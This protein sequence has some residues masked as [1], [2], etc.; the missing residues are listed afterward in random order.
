VR[1][2]IR[3]YVE[4][5]PLPGGLRWA[6]KLWNTLNL[7]I[8]R[9]HLQHVELG[10]PRWHRL[11]Q[12]LSLSPSFGPA[13]ERRNVFYSE[14]L[15]ACGQ[16]LFVHPHTA[17]YYPGN[18]TLGD[19]VFINRGVIL[20]AP[21]PI[22]IGDKALIGPYST[23][24]SGSHRYESR[25]TPIDEQGHKYGEIRIGNDVWIGGHVCILP[26]VE[27]SDGAVIGAGAVVTKSVPAY[28][29][30]TGVPGKIKGFR[31]AP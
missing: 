23:I 24:N 1:T 25:G 6:A 15:E 27:I 5:N 8:F 16:G 12:R 28:A 22:Q 11:Q 20:M 7:A 14:T 21:V 29:I 10:S 18:I 2:E 30:V 19:E 17:F 13:A 4:E 9:A 31:D 3:K 26:G